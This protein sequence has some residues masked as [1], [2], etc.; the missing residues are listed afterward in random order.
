MV[1]A[2]CFLENV[3]KHCLKRLEPKDFILTAVGTKASCLYIFRIT[4]CHVQVFSN[5]VEIIY[6]LKLNRDWLCSLK[7]VAWI[8]FGL[9]RNGLRCGFFSEWSM[10]KQQ[11]EQFNVKTCKLVF[12]ANLVLKEGLKSDIEYRYNDFFNVNLCLNVH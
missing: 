3:P 2:L 4:G 5:L 10:S 6:E 9:E 7:S 11:Q 1:Y 8:D 12:W